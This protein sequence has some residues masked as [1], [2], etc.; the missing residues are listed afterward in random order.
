MC[1][2][3][4]Y[5]RIKKKEWRARAKLIAGLGY[6]CVDVYF[7]WN[8]HETAPGE[9]DFSGERDLD[10]FLSICE[11]NNLYVMARPGPYICSEWDGGG[12]PAWVLC[13]PGV[14]QNE[15]AY[16]RQ[17]ERW[18]SR[19]LPLLAHHQHSG[20]GGGC[21]ILLQLENE[22]DFFDCKDV[23]GYV[24]RLRDMALS[25]RI[26]VPLFTCAGQGDIKRS[27][28]LIGHCREDF[29]ENREAFDEW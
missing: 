7:P 26:T 4:F 24:E 13:N 5:F 1:A 15:P 9:F 28:G 16:L 10:Y 23:G 22:L 2:S 3:F 8:Y 21:I 11:E 20:R 25:H 19:I 6:N 17:V 29:S 18:Y 14:R 27:G 12:L